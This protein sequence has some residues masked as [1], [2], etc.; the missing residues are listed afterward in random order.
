[1]KSELKVSQTE[2]LIFIFS[3]ETAKSSSERNNQRKVLMKTPRR[4]ES[5]SF[6]FF[7]FRENFVDKK[8]NFVIRLQSF[9]FVLGR[10]FN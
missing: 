5:R 6:K 4:R 1:M 8:V 7:Q 9:K 3:L 2:H 10:V